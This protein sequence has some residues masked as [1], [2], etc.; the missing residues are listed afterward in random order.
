MDFFQQIEER[1]T[2]KTLYLPTYRRVEDL[3]SSLNVDKDKQGQDYIQFGLTDVEDKL[4]S[5]KKEILTSSN[6]SMSRI[7]SEILNRLVNGLTVNDDDRS[8]IINNSNDIELLLN[9]FGRSLTLSDKNKIISLVKN[10]YEV[11]KRKTTPSFIF[12]QRCIML[13]LNSKLKIKL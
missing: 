7:N 9:R 10:E 4:E 12:F 13:F 11:G 6:D 8:I 2:L 1:F 3:L 5:I